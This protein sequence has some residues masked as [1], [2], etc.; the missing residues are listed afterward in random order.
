MHRRRHMAGND[1]TFEIQAAPHDADL[2]E[3]FPLVGV[4]QTQEAAVEEETPGR[5]S[6]NPDELNEHQGINLLHP[7]I[8]MSL[9]PII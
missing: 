9:V 5:R 8:V 6:A 4:L 1:L 7:I 3:R 2:L